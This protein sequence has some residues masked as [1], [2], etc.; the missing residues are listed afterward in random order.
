MTTRV[1]VVDDDNGMCALLRMELE[2]F[3][4]DVTTVAS[5]PV[6]LERVGAEEFDVVITD[7][8]MPQS[9]GATRH[10]AH[11]TRHPRSRH[12]RNSCRSV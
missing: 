6:A 8:A 11:W 4:Y 12:Q 7:L 5:A 2:R 1:L 10:R 9:A 3:G